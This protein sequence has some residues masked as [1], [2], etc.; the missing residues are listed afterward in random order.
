[1]IDFSQ[2]Q[3]DTM[4]NHF[5]S[6]VLSY[7]NLLSNSPQDDLNELLE[8]QLDEMVNDNWDTYQDE[9]EQAAEHFSQEEQ[10]WEEQLNVATYHPLDV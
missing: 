5:Y 4:N 10:Y 6:D 3:D 2:L 8:E 7:Q 9:I 1:M